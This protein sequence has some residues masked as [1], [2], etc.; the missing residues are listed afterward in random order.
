MRVPPELVGRRPL[1]HLPAAVAVLTTAVLLAG[2]FVNSDANHAVATQSNRISKLQIVVA[3]NPME[4]DHLIT[5]ADLSL[6]VRPI[7]GL[8]EGAIT[9]PEDLIGKTLQMAVREHEVLT[10]AAVEHRELVNPPA[11]PAAAVPSLASEPAVPPEPVEVSVPPPSSSAAQAR[12]VEAVKVERTAPP[13]AVSKPPPALPVVAPI[14]RPAAPPSSNLARPQA[15]LRE[16]KA[17]TGSST[18]RRFRS[19]VWVPG[20]NYSYA[21]DRRGTVRVVDPNGNGAPLDDYQDVEEDE[22]DT[23]AA[24]AGGER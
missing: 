14:P 9:R 22:G 3:R 5:A 16:S 7:A 6:D 13:H 1:W 20:Q 21:V 10:S 11:E 15:P 24:P 12:T 2:V 8:P 17:A 18:K 4:P 19:Y 23:P